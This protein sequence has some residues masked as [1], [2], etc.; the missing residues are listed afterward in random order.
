MQTNKIYLILLV[1][2]LSWTTYSQTQGATGVNKDIDIV[3]VYTQV[4]NE[5]YG[6]VLIYKELA[7]AYYF[8][9]NYTESKKWFEKLF[10]E[11]EPQEKIHLYRYQQSLKALK[12]YTEDNVYLTDFIID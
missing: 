12:L 3:K 11:V 6:T 2:C 7:N 4:V 9:S 1:V 5:G 10:S 8:R